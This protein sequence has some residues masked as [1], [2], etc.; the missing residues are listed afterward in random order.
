MSA[1]LDYI[2]RIPCGSDTHPCHTTPCYAITLKQSSSNLFLFLDT[3]QYVQTNRIS[4][5]SD[6]TVSLIGRQLSLREQ[7]SSHLSSFP[8]IRHISKPQAIHR[9]RRQGS[10]HSSPRQWPTIWLET[11][12]PNSSP[13]SRALKLTV[14]N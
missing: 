3:Y 1:S 14:D 4:P 10:R 13:S 5:K 6:V 11:P 8:N 9:A 2:P 7:A 12:P